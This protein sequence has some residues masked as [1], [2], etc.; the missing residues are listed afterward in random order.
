[1]V[2]AKI[3]VVDDDPGISRDVSGQLVREGFA[4]ETASSGPSALEIAR[5]FQPDLVILDID[6]PEEGKDLDTSMDGIEV[7]RRL[8]A[9]SDVCVL[10]LTSTS[11]GYVKVAALSL[12]ADDYVTKPFD[13]KELIARVEAILRRAKGTG[14]RPPVLTFSQLRIDPGARRVWKDDKVVEL[15]PIEFDLLYALASQP[16]QTFTRARLIGKAWSYRYSGDERLVDVH[17][18]RLR[19]KIEVDP[20]KPSLLHTV[21]GKGYLFDEAGR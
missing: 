1:M 10:M 7:L 3:L 12:G 16:S 13:P 6:I 15:T 2:S 19:K 17:M 20:S 18:A 5:N 9:E 14:S 8:R 11:I 4:V 21:W